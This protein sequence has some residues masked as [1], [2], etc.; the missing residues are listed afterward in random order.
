MIENS[1]DKKGGLNMEWKGSEKHFWMSL[2]SKLNLLD[3]LEGMKCDNNT[4]WYTWCNARKGGR[5]I[6][7]RLDKF[8]A[9]M[10]LEAWYI[11]NDGIRGMVYPYT[12]SNHHPIKAN[13]IINNE[14]R[15][16]SKNRGNFILNTK[17]LK[18][19][20]CKANIITLREVKK[21]ILKGL[22]PIERWNQN[23]NGWKILCQ[24]IG[25][26]RP[27]DMRREKNFL[28][29]ELLNVENIIQNEP[30]SEE[31]YE[32][33]NRAKCFEKI[34]SKQNPRQIK[35]RSKL[36]QLSNGQKG[37]IFLDI[38]KKRG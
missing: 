32:E 11:L 3:P 8:Y 7:C 14:G 6:F 38:S 36:N 16:V 29:D 24:T 20:D 31:I 28:Q 37:S 17:L 22:I 9:N 12:L 35:V 2:K 4:I 33:L 15:K 10:E 27:M 34:A 18:D 21:W 23:V 1:E 5:R 13:I 30:L 26:K 25:N 19:D